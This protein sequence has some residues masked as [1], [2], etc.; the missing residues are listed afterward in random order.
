MTRKRK[1]MFGVV[2]ALAVVGAGAA[3]NA[4]ALKAKYTAHQRAPRRRR[5]RA[6]AADRLY[7]SW[8]IP[9]RAAS[10]SCSGN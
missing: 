4:T 2:L 10:H 1:C 6:K 8:A 3:M 7:G 5:R 9:G